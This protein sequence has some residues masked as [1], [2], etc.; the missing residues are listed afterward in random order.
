MFGT[1]FYGLGTPFD[2]TPFDRLG[3]PFAA[4]LAKEPVAN[5][6]SNTHLA[7]A[8]DAAIRGSKL[9]KLAVRT[10][11]PSQP[12][13]AATLPA[14]ASA[15][16]GTLPSAST[17]T[18]PSH[19]STARQLHRPY[20]KPITVQLPRRQHLRIARLLDNFIAHIQTNPG[21]NSTATVPL[22]DTNGAAVCSLLF[23]CQAVSRLDTPVATCCVYT[24]VDLGPSFEMD[25][26]KL[27]CTSYSGIYDFGGKNDDPA[28]W[29]YGVAL[30]YKF[31]Y[32][33]EFSTNCENCERSNGACGS[34]TEPERV[35][36][37]IW[38]EF[39]KKEEEEEEEEEEEKEK[40]NWRGP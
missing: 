15:S 19:C 27:Q 38:L 2:D 32:N 34:A 33:N 21:N 12:T 18:T 36:S 24:P 1:P 14:K 35:S 37:Q 23:S 26:Q 31:N 40:Q 7:Q 16:I 39:E 5:N 20:T 17:T 29:Q 28:S 30:K 22:C 4:K 8:L 6:P 11:S 10:N 25:L 3:S 13:L 9:T